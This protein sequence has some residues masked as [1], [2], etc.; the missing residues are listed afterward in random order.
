MRFK[1]MKLLFQPLTLVFSKSS[2]D[3]LIM[4]I[5]IKLFESLSFATISYSLSAKQPL[6]VIISRMVCGV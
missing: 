5:L 2:A 6:F 1:E 4:P 3:L